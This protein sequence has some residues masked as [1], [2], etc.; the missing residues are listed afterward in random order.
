MAAVERAPAAFIRWMA[1]LEQEIS[2]LKS[3]RQSGD[4]PR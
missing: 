3:E 4:T 2:D 1:K